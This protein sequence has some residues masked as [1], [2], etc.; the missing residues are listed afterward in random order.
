MYGVRAFVSL[1]GRVRKLTVGKCMHASR[2]SG[3]HK[4]EK[5]LVQLMSGM[6]V[7]AGST[8]LADGKAVERC[9]QQS[10]LDG[11]D[12]GGGR[13]TRWTPITT[14][15]QAPDDDEACF[16]AL[17]HQERKVRC[18]CY[19]ILNMYDAVFRWRA[20]GG[21][22]GESGGARAA[23]QSNERSARIQIH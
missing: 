9:E 14:A 1:Y 17:R 21:R 22:E 8:V 16:R 7:G 3:V 5:L 19:T 4:I 13:P 12:G 20:D 15:T 18:G 11:M 2:A 10:E 6:R 23:R